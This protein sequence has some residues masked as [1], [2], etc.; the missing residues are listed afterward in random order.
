MLVTAGK[1]SLVSLAGTFMGKALS[2]ILRFLVIRLL[3]AKYFGFFAISMGLVAFVRIIVSIGL[4]R[5]GMRFLAKS[6]GSTNTKLLPQIIN[7]AMMIPLI[8][9]LVGS[10]LFY[11]GA[12]TIANFWF[13]KV[14]LIPIFRLFALAIPFVTLLKIGTELS[15]GFYTTKYAVLVENFIVPIL[16]ILLFLCLYFVSHGFKALIYG[17]IIANAVGAVCIVFFLFHQADRAFSIQQDLSISEFWLWWLSKGFSFEVIRYSFPLFLSGITAMLMGTIDVFMLGRFVD[18][19]MVGIYAA[20][21]MVAVFLSTSLVIPV[22]SIF[23]PLVAGHHHQNDLT[24]VSRLYLATTRWVAFLAV[25]LV[26]GV[27]LLRNYIMMIFGTGFV[28]S[29]ANVLLI[30]AIGHLINGLTGG[31]GQILSMAGHPKKEL[32]INLLI[33]ILNICL[34]IF[35]IPRYGIIGAASATSIA[36]CL[37]NIFRVIVVFKIF[38]IQPFTVKLLR[39]FALGFF[40]VFANLLFQQFI[41]GGYDLLL[42]IG[43]CGVLIWFIVIRG[44]EPED[45]VVLREVWKRFNQLAVNKR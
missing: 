6:L 27:I 14:E 9:S 7:T 38:K 43:T 22:N 3:G 5:G 30:L 19:D 2:L 37:V 36:L 44:L 12:D 23:A 42:A 18:A 20:A 34:N 32:C 40:L 1:G 41:S 15:K 16:L 28:E 31:V 45:R 25:P 39:I 21:S 4:P 35:L 17:F 29:G 8:L 26:S 11:L 24:A 13:H 33:V 10:G